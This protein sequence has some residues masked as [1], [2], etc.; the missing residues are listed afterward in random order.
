[1]PDAPRSV[2][3]V[4]L[5]NICRSPMAEGIFRHRLAGRSASPAFHVDSAGTG[6]WH[7]GEAPD[8]RTQEVLRRHGAPVPGPARQARPDDVEQFDVIMAMDRS[9]LR[10]LHRLYPSEA[11]GRVHLML[12][13]TTGGDVP[14]PY[15]GGPDG[16]DQVYGLLDEAIEAWLGRWG[17]G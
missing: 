7:V 10:N 8:P 2:L 17:L 5:G 16:F 6:A 13:P 15:Y 14:D 11:H 4:C 12:E 1:M 3:F 9:N